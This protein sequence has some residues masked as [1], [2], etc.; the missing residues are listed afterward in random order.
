MFLNWS[1]GIVNLSSYIINNRERINYKY[2]KDNRYYIGS[3]AI[4]SGNK[5]VIQH[6]MKQSGMRWGIKGGQYIA[7]LRGKYKSKLWDE[8]IDA[9][10]A[11]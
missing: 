3:V 6:R 8:V 1:N 9:I 2:F 10:Y 4:E 7:S 5:T 11:S